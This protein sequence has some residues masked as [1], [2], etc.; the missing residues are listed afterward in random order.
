MESVTEPA[1]IATPPLAPPAQLVPLGSAPPASPQILPRQAP[2]ATIAPTSTFSCSEEIGEILAALA[3]AQ[4]NFKKF[5]KLYTADVESK[6][7]GTKYSYDYGGFEDLLAAVR[8]A[9]NKQGIAVL[10]PSSVRSVSRGAEQGL[11]IVVT[12]F[13]GHKS[14]QWFRNDYQLPVVEVGP[15]AVGGAQSFAKRYALQSMVGIAPEPAQDDDA[16][17]AQR[18]AARQASDAAGRREPPPVQTVPMPQ[19][20]SATCSE[21]NGTGKLTRLGGDFGKTS[22]SV[23][24]CWKCQPSN[25]SAAPKL[26]IARLQKKESGNGSPYWA[27]ELSD[28]QQALT[29]DIKKGA[30]LEDGKVRGDAVTKFTTRK[31][32]SYTHIE[33]LEIDGVR[34]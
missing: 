8:P 7:T 25:K 23:V 4:L 10:Q 6:R 33:I 17:A 31:Q 32:G 18:A 30:A 27:V 20:Q 29:F 9:L 28:K 13:L 11:V 19:R 14:G 5:E 15:Q 26:T 34:S 21:C 1:S 12:T 22:D 2:A 16:A 24:P 3:L